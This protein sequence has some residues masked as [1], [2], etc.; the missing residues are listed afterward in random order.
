M[1]AQIVGEGLAPATRIDKFVFPRLRRKSAGAELNLRAQVAPN[2]Q[3]QR[4]AAGMPCGGGTLSFRFHPS[5]LSETI[6]RVRC[7]LLLGVIVVLTLRRTVTLM[8][9]QR[10]LAVMKH[11]TGFNIA[12]QLY[13]QVLI[14]IDHAAFVNHST[15]VLLPFANADVASNFLVRW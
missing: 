2:A 10:L 8:L 9:R 11:Y 3:A 5:A 13:I 4:R 7:S 15:G 6:P 1:F 12:Y 14:F